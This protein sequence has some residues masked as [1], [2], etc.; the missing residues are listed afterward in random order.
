MH[1]KKVISAVVG[2]LLISVISGCSSTDSSAENSPFQSNPYSS[3]QGAIET[4]YQLASEGNWKE[5]CKHV[6]D[7]ARAAAIRYSGSSDGSCESGFAA[8]A[9]QKGSHVLA[10][11]DGWK[12]S[13][14]QMF[15]TNNKIL[16][17]L[18]ESRLQNKK[19][20]SLNL[21]QE[22]SQE[23]TGTKDSETLSSVTVVFENKVTEDDLV[24][25]FEFSDG[26]WKISNTI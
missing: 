25:Q 14:V 8:K 22:I 19:K 12:I 2:F 15:D 11:Q 13:E 3:A 23:N 10:T 6:T 20:I 16:F 1:A 24:N 18:K 21:A 5:L 7:N 4:S 9:S 26:E 17:E